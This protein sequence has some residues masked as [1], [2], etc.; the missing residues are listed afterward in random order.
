MSNS[1]KMVTK[2]QTLDN[3]MTKI[4]LN[5]VLSP[6][7]GFQGEVVAYVQELSDSCANSIMMWTVLYWI[8]RNIGFLSKNILQPTPTGHSHQKCARNRWVKVFRKVF[9]KNLAVNFTTWLENKTQQNKRCFNKIPCFWLRASQLFKPGFFTRVSLPGFE[10]GWVW[11]IWVSIWTQYSSSEVK[12]C[13]FSTWNMI[14][15]NYWHQ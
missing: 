9:S 5:A 8:T 10:L 4:I 6:L 3:G 1:G 12:I 11:K 2:D 7:F 14:R 13:C 15:N